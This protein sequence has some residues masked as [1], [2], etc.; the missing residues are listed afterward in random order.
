MGGG[1]VQ[2]ALIA[3]L[4]ATDRLTERGAISISYVPN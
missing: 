4:S 3:E 1:G 2:V